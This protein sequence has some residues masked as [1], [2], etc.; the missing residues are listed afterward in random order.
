MINQGISPTIDRTLAV[1]GAGE[2]PGGM[3]GATA[4][5]PETELKTRV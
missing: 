3:V 4:V 5:M 1:L 2:A